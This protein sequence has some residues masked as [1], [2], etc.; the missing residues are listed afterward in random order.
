MLTFEY[1]KSDESLCIHADSEGLRC[2]AASLQN[3]AN[4]IEKRGSDHIHLMTKEWCG[5][6]LSGEAQSETSE[7]IKHVKVF[8]WKS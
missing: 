8:G 6:E 1:E 7:L 3:L 4:Q 5:R 2:L